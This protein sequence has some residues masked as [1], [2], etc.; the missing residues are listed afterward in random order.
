MIGVEM[1]E[2]VTIAAIGGSG[3][4]GE[5]RHIQVTPTFEAL[6]PLTERPLEPIRD[7]LARRAATREVATATFRHLLIDRRVRLMRRQITR[8]VRHVTLRPRAPGP[9]CASGHCQAG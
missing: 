1:G 2:R 4:A 3:I 6:L 5:I 9:S 8:P 7:Y